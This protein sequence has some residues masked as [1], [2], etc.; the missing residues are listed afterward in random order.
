MLD[1]VLPPRKHD[2]LAKPAV[3]GEL[4][5]PGEW[6]GLLVRDIRLS[7]CCLAE[8]GD[9]VRRSITSLAQRGIS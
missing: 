6:R 3:W 8:A 9:D 5:R 1:R 2:F 4:M 7:T